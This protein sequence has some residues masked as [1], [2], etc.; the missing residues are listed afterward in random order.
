MNI[1]VSLTVGELGD[2][3]FELFDFRALLA[4]DDAGA[5]RIDIDLGLA[6]RPFDFNLLDAG[7]VE[8]GL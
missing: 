6:R 3:L 8:P 4:D 2:L 5:R 1:D 7:V